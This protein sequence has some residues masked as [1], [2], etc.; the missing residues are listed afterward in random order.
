[1]R[2]LVYVITI[3]LL[4][5][6]TWAQEKRITGKIINQE[7][8]QP[9]A[10]ATVT[11]SG[12]NIATQTGNDGSFSISVPNENAVL[13]VTYVGMEP[14]Q[15]RVGNQTDLTISMLSTT[16]SLNEVV[17]TG[18]QTQR[19]VDLIGSVAVVDLKPVKNTSSGNPMQALQGRVAGLYIERTGTP[20]GDNSRILIRGSNTLN[21]T[22][23]LYII[24]GAPTKNPQIFQSLNPSTIES[25]Q[26]LKDASAA[27]IYGSRA[28][29]GVIIV[30]TKSGAGR[31]NIQVNSSMSYQTPKPQKLDMLDAEGRGRALW[32]AAVNDRTDP[33]AV[34][35]GIYTYDWNGNYDNPV[36]NNVNIKPFVGD[37]PNVPVGNTDWQD[38]AYDNAWVTN[39]ELTI[40][41]GTKA[42]SILMSL[43]YINNSGILAYTDFR[44][45][46]GRLNGSTQ[47]YDGKLKI[48]MNTE[49]STSD[50][51]LATND[52]GGAATPGLAI[53]LAPTIPVYTKDGQFAGPKGAGYSDR[54]NPVNMQWLN[55]W[56]NNNRTFAF[57][58]TFLEVTPIKHLVLRTNL[59]VEYTTNLFKDVQLAFQEGFLGRNVN[60]L[61]RNT[62]RFLSL[63]W[64]NTANYQF[65]IGENKFNVLGG[66]EAIRQEFEE[67]GATRE[68]FAQQ[69]EDFFNLN[70]GSGRSTNFGRSSESRLLSQFGKINYAYSDRYLASVTLRRD[71]SSRFGSENRYGFFPA[72]NIG[73]RINNETF[74]QDIEAISNLKLRAG[75]GRAG[76]QDIFGLD[77]LGDYAS[78]GLYEPRYGTLFNNGQG[79]P[80]Q[81][82]NVGTAYDITG[83]NSGNLPSGFVSVQGPNPNLKW[84]STEEINLGVDFGF[85]N[86]KIFGSFDY[87]S[88]TI[89]DILIRPEIASAVGEGRR[90]F[91]NG[92]TKENKGFEFVLGYRNQ[93]RGGLSYSVQGNLSRFRDKIT[94]LPQELI[95]NFPGDANQTIL[96]RTEQSIFGYKTDGLFQN[97]AD[98]DKHADQIGKGVGRIRY[99][100]LNNDGVVNADDRTWIGTTLPKFEYG[101]RADLAYKNF[102]LSF[103]GSGISGRHN[104]VDYIFLNN[105][106][107]TRENRGPG[108]LN[109]WTPQNTGSKTPALT[110]VDRNN[111]TRPS[112]Y[113]F[114]NTSYFK[115]R[116]IQ[117][118]YNLPESV[119]NTLH[120]SQLRLYLMGENVFWFKNKEYEISDPEL[121]NF[122]LIPI[123]TSITFGVNITFN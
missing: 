29:N 72:A 10:G 65:E 63:T 116:N 4:S 100:D 43:G 67:F 110:L 71:G 21:N 113:L 77:P 26:I 30:T 78:L 69:T 104:F 123:P 109:A 25:V 24:D 74:M 99:V 61:A 92:A 103:F 37:D 11:V 51:T 64:S 75:W 108:V 119:L 23:P 3:L 59:G 20:N 88:R 8:K 45:Y 50:Q 90:K 76:N 40:S 48:G 38:A 73:W 118:G 117:L 18:Y 56:D 68:G 84:E 47:L 17:V 85:L 28:S 42:S 111:E 7:T 101:I 57:G 83:A 15:I 13:S 70:A 120:M 97:Q 35:P 19:K 112:D 36:L 102:D 66:I 49:F 34:A 33:N 5:F 58:N 81:W 98:V 54:N 27:S 93:T 106:I 41:G 46:S 6:N 105:F 9:V 94:E 79:F 121:P 95:P 96:G 80:G 53:N 87:F 31:L 107:N 82:L 115:M 86:E 1:M 62:N 52:L 14:Q 89:S 39:N 2:T 32:Q 16:S 22:D 114:V 91:V 44:R 55:R 12:T 60:S 122:N